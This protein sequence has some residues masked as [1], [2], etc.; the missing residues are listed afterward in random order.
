MKPKPPPSLTPREREVLQTWGKF[1]SV[2][3]VAR[4][5]RMSEHTVNTHLKRT[6]K[7]L[8]VKKTLWAWRQFYPPSQDLNSDK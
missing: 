1:L 7:K 6:R 3:S 4:E 2:Q 8:G 5:L